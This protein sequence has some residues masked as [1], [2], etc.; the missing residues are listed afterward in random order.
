MRGRERAATDDRPRRSALGEAA[1]LL[2]PRARTES[3][4][5]AVLDGSHEPEA[6]EAAVERLR[7]LGYLNDAAW[8]RHYVEGRRSRGRGTRVLRR[9]LADHGIDPTLAES[10]LDGRDEREAAR[11]AAR[12][13][14]RSLAGLDRDRRYRR[15]AGFLARR[16]FGSDVV[17]S[18][19]RELLDG[20][21][22]AAEQ[23]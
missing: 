21:P 1:A 15:L 19:L 18:T 17:A 7:S 9:E 20:E 10:A 13:R 12:P 3:E 14:L 5:R 2:A 16:G 4:L 8:T 11:A 22:E 6:V 23:S